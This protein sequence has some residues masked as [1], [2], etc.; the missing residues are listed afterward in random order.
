MHMSSNGKQAKKICA[1]AKSCG[2]ARDKNGAN[3]DG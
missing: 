1:A 3:T 2:V